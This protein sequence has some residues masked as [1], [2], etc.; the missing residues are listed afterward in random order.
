MTVSE[1]DQIVTVVADQVDSEIDFKIALIASLGVVI[2]A[3]IT[4]L[5]QWGLYFFKNGTKRKLDKERTSLL[6]KMLENPNHE[7]RKLSTL[8]S[9]IGAD[10]EETKRLLIHLQARGSED[11]QPLWALISKKP[12][13]FRK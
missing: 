2:G 12:L 7:W 11:G 1:I 6:K 8:S 4:V 5:G 13:L 10:E 3:L 9:V